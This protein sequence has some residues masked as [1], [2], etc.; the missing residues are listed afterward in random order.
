MWPMA[1]VPMVLMTP[2]SMLTPQAI[3]A[4]STRVSVRP[5]PTSANDAMYSATLRFPEVPVNTIATLYIQPV[6]ER[7]QGWTHARMQCLGRTQTLLFQK[8][9]TGNDGEGLT[10]KHGDLRLHLAHPEVQSSHGWTI[11]RD[12]TQNS[13]EANRQFTH[14]AL[15]ISAKESAISSINRLHI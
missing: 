11:V 1:F 9:E 6:Y 2:E 10:A 4:I 12:A 15:Q 14:Y 7:P 5:C 8:V 3:A 13:M